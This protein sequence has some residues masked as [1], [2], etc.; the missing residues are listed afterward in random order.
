[1]M[2]FNPL[3]CLVA[4]LSTFVVGFIWYNPKVFGTIWMN[5]SNMTEEKAQQ[6]NMIKIFGLTL[7][8]SLLI[9]FTL[10]GMVIHEIGALQLNG[11]NPADPAYLDYVKSCGEHFRSF[12]HG[13][14]HGFILGLMFVLP[15]V[16]IN[17]LFEQKSWRYMLITGGY[18]VVSL[19]IMGAIICGWK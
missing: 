11:G 19:T 15:M 5:E 12:K 10:P 18:W 16:S 6:G 1:M 17:G 7:V 3:A 2:P 14:L 4:A 13:A 9:S 8:Y